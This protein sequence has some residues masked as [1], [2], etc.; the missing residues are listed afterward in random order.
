[1][2]PGWKVRPLHPKLEIPDVAQVVREDAAR[3]RGERAGHLVVLELVHLPAADLDRA[4]RGR[5]V[6][7]RADEPPV[8][9]CDLAHARDERGVLGEL[10]GRHGRARERHGERVVRRRQHGRLI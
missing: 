7:A 9:F 10:A 4:V 3:E 1:M 8:L 5:V 6:L 2:I